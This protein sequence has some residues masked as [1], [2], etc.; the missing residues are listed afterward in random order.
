L[1]TVHFD[2]DL[3]ASAAVELLLA[4]IATA[5]QTPVQIRIPVGLRLGGTHGPAPAG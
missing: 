1:T 3:L 2:L 5:A 4:E